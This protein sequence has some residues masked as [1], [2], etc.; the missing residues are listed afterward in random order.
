MPDAAANTGFQESFKPP[1]VI[2][3]AAVALALAGL[4]WWRFGDSVFA[5][6]MMSAFM[7]CF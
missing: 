6:S 2:S 3:V 4:L 7:A 5:T 1:V